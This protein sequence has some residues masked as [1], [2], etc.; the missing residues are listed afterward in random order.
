MP[1]RLQTA[2]AFSA[3]SASAWFLA[4]AHFSSAVRLYVLEKFREEGIEIP[5]PQ[6]VLHMADADQDV[7]FINPPPEPQ[8]G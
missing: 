6:R 8:A 7:E 4:L 5:F 3:A 1:D 2:S